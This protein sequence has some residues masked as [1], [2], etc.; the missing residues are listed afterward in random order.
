MHVTA[1]GLRKGPDVDEEE[2][3]GEEGRV[4]RLPDGVVDIGGEAATM[5]VLYH[6]T[7][8]L[9]PNSCALLASHYHT[10]Y[11]L[12]KRQPCTLNMYMRD[13]LM[14]VRR[15]PAPHTTRGR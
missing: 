3:A 4:F 8:M 5:T 13:V 14:Y 7:I 2:E 1:A 9:Y 6:V 11:A 10:N 12:I 15:E